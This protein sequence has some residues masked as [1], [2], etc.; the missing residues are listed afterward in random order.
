MLAAGSDIDAKTLDGQTPLMYAVIR[1]KSE[2]AQMLVLESAD[3]NAVDNFQGS[4]LSYAILAQLPQ[5]VE[6]LIE[7]GAEGN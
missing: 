4:A 7:A 3:V 6:L 5:T 1:G 2:F